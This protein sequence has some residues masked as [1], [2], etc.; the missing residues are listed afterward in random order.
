M[1]K[2]LAISLALLLVIPL[3]GCAKKDGDNEEEEKEV[4]AEDLLKKD[5]DDVSIVMVI[6]KQD[7]K[8]DEYAI[9]RQLFESLGATITVAAKTKGTC[10]GLDGLEV[11]ADLA[12]S[13]V[14]MDKFDGAIFIG[15]P[16]VESLY[17]DRDAHVVAQKTAEQGKVLGAICLAP[18]V[19]A[20]AGVLDGV[21][22][23]VFETAKYHEA[24]EMI[25]KQ[26]AIYAIS[27][28]TGLPY[29]VK[30]SGN[31]ITANG[32]PAAQ[33]FAQRIAGMLKNQKILA[34]QKAKEE[35]MK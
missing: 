32:P 22:V 8:D 26:G 29:K 30:I 15:G 10:A 24:V 27:E 4:T 6:A 19:L 33:D 14:N 20:N 11:E 9:P 1:R 35:E 18:V 5:L 13:E 28:K 16:G 12:L 3:W 34:E 25:K 7:F 2:V 17:D 21:E 31:I 23:T